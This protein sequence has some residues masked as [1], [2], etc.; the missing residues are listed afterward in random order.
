MT[1]LKLY[2]KAANHMTISWL[3]IYSSR[4]KILYSLS[5]DRRT[6][7]YCEK[8]IV[9]LIIKREPRNTFECLNYLRCVLEMSLNGLICKR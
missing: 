4:R 8:F 2:S 5:N 1:F 9:L 3:G 6:P 7:Q